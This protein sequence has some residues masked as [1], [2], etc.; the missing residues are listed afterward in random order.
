M[1]FLCAFLGH[2]WD[3]DGW[4][5]IGHWDDGGTPRWRRHKTCTRCRLE[6]TYETDS[7]NRPLDVV[8]I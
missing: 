4:W 2:R 7:A 3:Y 8:E 6:V 5:L 1:P